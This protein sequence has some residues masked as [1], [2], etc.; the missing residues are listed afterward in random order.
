MLGTL[1][2]SALVTTGAVHML[3][4]TQLYSP[5]EYSHCLHRR[6]IHHYRAHIVMHECNIAL[7]VHVPYSTF[8]YMYAQKRCWS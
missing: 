7:P 5:I 3:C 6:D 8:T 1:S 4:S 2:T